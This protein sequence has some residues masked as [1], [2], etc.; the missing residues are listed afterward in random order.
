ML[1]RTWPKRIF[2]LL[3]VWSL[4]LGSQLGHFH[5]S[6][7]GPAHVI[8]HVVESY[9][10]DRGFRYGLAREWS[11]L[12]PQGFQF[13]SPKG[14][15]SSLRSSILQE[16]FLEVEGNYRRAGVPLRASKDH[17]TA[18]S[19]GKH[20]MTG[21]GRVWWFFKEYGRHKVHHYEGR[22]HSRLAKAGAGQMGGPNNQLRDAYWVPQ[23]PGGEH[24]SRP[25]RL[26]TEAETSPTGDG[27][28][29]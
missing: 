4:D 2:L 24:H 28:T 21:H 12:V 18:Q 16:K 27:R 25:S 20:I 22:P 14:V 5:S 17:Q 3:R 11:L 9:G 6:R 8:N 10:R 26:G 23:H 19:S 29:S 13:R 15:W 7:G 1:W